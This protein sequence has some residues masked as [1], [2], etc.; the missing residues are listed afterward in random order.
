MKGYR[1][2]GISGMKKGKRWLAFCLVLGAMLGASV[3]AAAA[4]KEVDIYINGSLL[5]I[6]PSFG[7]PFYDG[8][9]RLQIPMRYIIQSCGYDVTW[10]NAQQTA[11][12][13]TKSGDVVITLGSN[14]IK[15]PAGPVQMDTSA[16]A[17]DGR[18]Y[19]PLRYAL[20]ALGFQV[21][22]AGGTAA[23][24]ISINGGI[25]AA[26]SRVPMTA[27][28]V[29]ALASPAV[30]YIE[31]S[32]LDGVAYAS[33]SGFFIDPSCVGVTNYHVIEGAYSAEITAIDGTKYEMGKVLYYDKDRDIAV[34][35]ALPTNNQEI[36]GHAPYLNLATPSSI[37]N[38]DV[39]YSIGSPL[40]L[41]N[42]ITD[43][44]VSNKDRT[45]PGDTKSYI[46]TSAPIS[47]GNSGGPLL[48]QYG[49]VVGINTAS[50]TEGQNL[51]LAV[52]VSD[53]A[54]VDYN[55]SS[56]WMFL[57]QVADRETG[58]T[59]PTNIRIVDEDAD[60]AYLQWNPVDGADYYHFYYKTQSE[61][62]FWYDPDETYPDEPCRMYYQKGYSTYYSG[63]TPGITYNI[64]VTSVKDGVE[65]ADSSVFTFTKKDLSGGSGTQTTGTNTTAYYSNAWWCPDFGAFS[66]LTPTHSSSN[67]E[68]AIYYYK[69][70]NFGYVEN[71]FSLLE[72]DGF[73]YNTEMS[74]VMSTEDDPKMCYTKFGNTNYS[75]TCGINASTGE[76]IVFF[77]IN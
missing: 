16:V 40:G 39:V 65:S 49:E 57:F 23:D 6:P 33:G 42:S 70:P 60:A 56:N 28:E 4:G 71:Y 54:S 45:F 47:H 21:D 68:S 5:N 72:A 69:I 48:N 73:V 43:G 31:V 44:L 55:N 32:G 50:L 41:Q 25:G 19:I 10:S 52:P 34:F 62:S 26:S 36:Y 67:G 13:P 1:R 46:Q 66:G 74:N 15:T 18:T 30:F 7:E 8:S 61:D 38:G 27:A 29:S 75:V 20:E 14:T 22:W 64:I 24:T 3:P 2:K 35:D 37:H 9:G 63:L 11:T 76:F 77:L 17:K 51:N 53:L 59:P 12:V 58:I